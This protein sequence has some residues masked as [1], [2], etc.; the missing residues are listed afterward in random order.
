MKEG[1]FIFLSA[2]VPYRPDWTEGAKPVEIEEAVVSLARAVF[3]RGGRLLFGG[4][5]SISPL[6]SAVAGEYYPIE[7]ARQIRPVVT[8]Q[9][10]WFRGKL[11]DETWEMHRMGF[12]AIE[13]TPKEDGQ[14]T[15]LTIMR[16]WM[17]G[18]M[19]T[20]IRQRNRVTP[21]QA[22]VAVGGMEGIL[23]EAAIFFR[24]RRGWDLVNLPPFYA[25]ESC[26]GAAQRLI[27]PTDNWEGRLRLS[28]SVRD[29]DAMELRVAREAGELHGIEKGW[30][31]QYATFESP[32]FRFL[33]YASMAQWL[34]DGL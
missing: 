14:R 17:L 29:H 34:V 23:E 12:S 33:P 32:E 1:D 9:S 3:A 25:F 30:R 10:E 21:P 27:E 15:S 4:H 24:R 11:P 26:G 8:F 18:K 28:Q 7:P 16:E 20:D 31:D 13:W 6:V 22:M 2:S 5:P 19:P